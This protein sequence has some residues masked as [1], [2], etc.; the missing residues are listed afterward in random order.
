MASNGKHH[1]AFLYRRRKGIEFWNCIRPACD[2][3]YSHSLDEGV[4][5]QTTGMREESDDNQINVPKD[6][7]DFLRSIQEWYTAHGAHGDGNTWS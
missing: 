4:A 5:H 3:H 1:Q 6:S 7:C 2:Q